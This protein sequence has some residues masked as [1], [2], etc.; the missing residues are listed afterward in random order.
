MRAERVHRS[1]W[2]TK[3]TRAETASSQQHGEV[4]LLDDDSTVLTIVEGVLANAGHR[5]HCITEPTVALSIA[6]EHE[7][8]KA[9]VCDIY[10]PEMTG[11]EFID[12]LNSLRPSRK[13]PPVLLMTAQPSVE[14]AVEALR[15]G[16][17][18]FLIKPV[19]PNELIESVHRAMR[20]DVSDASRLAVGA[21]ADIRVLTRQAEDLAQ[22]LRKLCLDPPLYSEPRSAS[23]NLDDL[24]LLELMEGLRRMQFC[25]QGLP[26]DDT[27]WDLLLE[28]MRAERLN[29]KLSV[30]DLMLSCPGVSPTTGLRRLN[31]LVDIGFAAR[32]QDPKDRRRDYVSLTPLGRARIETFLE[33][34]A[35]HVETACRSRHS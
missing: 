11:L 18:D 4:L 33:E 21:A 16:V 25:D 28:L 31:E 12:A 29:V 27:A 15:L 19:R 9:V 17:W 10:M 14:T 22:A 3:P 26:L 1:T 35:E 8:I 23:A 34:A 30:S 13:V 20:R 7:G 32:V 5:C 24:Q 6:R 2:S